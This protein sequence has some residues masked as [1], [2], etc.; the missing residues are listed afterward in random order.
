LAGQGDATARAMIV[1]R[2]HRYGWAF[3]ERRREALASCFAENAVWEGNVQGAEPVGPIHGRDA[4]VTWLAGFWDRQEDQRRH[5]MPSVVVDR[6]TATT[7]DV[8]VHLVLTSAAGASLSIV[9][10]S[11]YR[12]EL[13]EQRGGWRIRRLFEGFDVAF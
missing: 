8:L 1:E 6:Q 12:M 2:V 9:L 4:I 13:V 11:F 5:L 10:T 3:D 7:A